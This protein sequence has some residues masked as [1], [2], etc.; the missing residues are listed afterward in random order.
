MGGYDVEAADTCVGGMGGFGLLL[1]VGDI[2]R[3]EAENVEG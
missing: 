3:S 1:E 2:I